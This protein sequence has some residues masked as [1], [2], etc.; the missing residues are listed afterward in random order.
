VALRHGELRPT[1]ALFTA[2]A[3]EIEETLRD[4][5]GRGARRTKATVVAGSAM[6]P[7][8]GTARVHNTSLCFDPA[9][10]IAG[11]TRKVNVVPTIE[12]ELGMT[13][14]LPDEVPVL[15]TPAGLLATT[16]CY[17]GFRVPH[18][19]QEPEF[20]PLARVLDARGADV[21]AWPAA[22][23]WRWDEA[24]PFG[25]SMLRREQWAREG[26][27]SLAPELENVRYVVNPML[28]GRV[29]EH[30]FDGRSSI[31]E[32]DSGRVRVV[33]EAGGYEAGPENEEV[34]RAVVP[35]PLAVTA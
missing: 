14:G 1:L 27:R 35:S 15:E 2:R 31:F 10:R 16:I 33:A 28:L 20:L 34:L 21:I 25:P 6:L 5:F 8:P 11:I 7:A 18:T 12:D 17:D 29:F 13:A 26:L 32:V 19:D 30:E 4:V 24:W 3:P 23:P 22:N 9:G